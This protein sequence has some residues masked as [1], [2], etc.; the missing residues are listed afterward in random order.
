MFTLY[1]GFVPGIKELTAGDPGATPYKRFGLRGMG[2]E[3]S[4][5]LGGTGVCDGCA[6]KITNTIDTLDAYTTVTIVNG[7]VDS[8]EVLKTRAKAKA[9]TKPYQWTFQLAIGASQLAH[10]SSTSTDFTL[11]ADI[12]ELPSVAFYASLLPANPTNFYFGIR[13]GIIELHSLRAYI[14]PNIDSGYKGGGSAFQAGLAT[15]IVTNLPKAL[16]KFHGF[17]EASYTYRK[18]NSVEWEPVAGKLPPYLP[19]ALPLNVLLISAGVE[20]PVKPLGDASK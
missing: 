1:G 16:S 3:T 18:I 8:T 9:E 4:I 10:F 13:T 2:F 19:H 7:K 20:I 5:S 14:A 11:H 17:L 6:A 12:R 15:G